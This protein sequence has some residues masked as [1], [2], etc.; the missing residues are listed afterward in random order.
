MH[1]PPLLSACG[2]CGVA[3]PVS[4]AQRSTFNDSIN[5][6][7]HLC[8]S[9]EGRDAATETTTGKGLSPLILSNSKRPLRGVLCTLHNS[10]FDDFISNTPCVLFFFWPKDALLFTSALAALHEMTFPA[11][12]LLLVALPS[13]ESPPPIRW[14]H[15]LLCSLFCVYNKPNSV[16][17]T[18]TSQIP[19]HD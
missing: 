10:T 18:T 11:F 13:G 3:L 8:L 4:F 1:H 15:K 14:P 12:L 7:R 17:T 16:C 19:P 2:G 6:R 9:S 5:S